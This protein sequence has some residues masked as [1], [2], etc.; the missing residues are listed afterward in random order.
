MGQPSLY[1]YFSFAMPKYDENVSKMN[2]STLTNTPDCES[3]IKL[4]PATL[5]DIEFLRAHDGEDYHAVM[6]GLNRIVKHFIAYSYEV[7]S[8][9]ASE[10]NEILEYMR[11]IEWAGQFI[12]NLSKEE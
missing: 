2:N 10:L 7:N 12:T 4:S 11:F 9:K 5:E 6:D 1:T 3:V 8:K